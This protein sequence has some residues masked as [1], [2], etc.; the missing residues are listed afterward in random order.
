VQALL[1]LFA[2][3][4]V[5]RDAK[6]ADRTPVLESGA[7]V[8]GDPTL[9]AINSADA[10]FERVNAF[11]IR[12]GACGNRRLDARQ[13]I[14]MNSVTPQ[15]V[16][17]LGIGRQPPHG[18]HARVPSESIGLR[19]PRVESKVEQIDGRLQPRFALAKRLFDAL[20]LGDV[21]ADPDQAIGNAH[22]ASTARQHPTHF[23]V[24]L[25]DPLLNLVFSAILDGTFCLLHAGGDFLGDHLRPID[26]V[27]LR[28]DLWRQ[29]KKRLVPGIAGQLAGS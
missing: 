29:T 9:D 26:L 6:E 13:V 20:V 1:F 18:L 28:S 24:A 12:I 4:D 14:V 7:A 3:G 2:L 8:R 5:D 16:V 19:V 10:I 27:G 17:D 21:E 11:T 15:P 22:H 25:S 23:T